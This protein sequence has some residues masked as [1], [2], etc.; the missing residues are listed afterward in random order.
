MSLAAGALVV[1]VALA[2]TRTE[3]IGGLGVGL[4]EPITRSFTM[5]DCGRLSWVSFLGQGAHCW[6]LLYPLK[7]AFV[8][9]FLLVVTLPF[10][11]R[12]FDAI[13]A[14]RTERTD[15]LW[16]ATLLPLLAGAIFTTSFYFTE[17][18]QLM[19][20]DNIRYLTPAMVPF[21]WLVLPQ[22]RFEGDL[23]DVGSPRI[24]RRHHLW[25][26]LAVGSYFVLELLHPIAGHATLGR[27]LLFFVL[28]LVPL[29]LGLVAYGTRYAIKERQVQGGVERRFV[30]AQAR[31]PEA[32]VVLGAV[33]V[34]LLAAWYFSAW[35]VTVGIGLVVALTAVSGKARALAMALVLLGSSAAGVQ[36]GLPL[37]ESAD[38]LARLPPG[39]H[40]GITEQIVYPAAVTPGH[41]VIRLIDPLEPIPPEMDALLIQHTFA[42]PG[43]TYEGFT[44]VREWQYDFQISPTLQ[45]PL[46]I[47]QN[48]LGQVVAFE[49][50]P[51]QT[52]YVRNGT[53][54]VELYR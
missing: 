54:L 49:D 52:L 23:A 32:R 4:I 53:G 40:V 21:L 45:A 14:G 10:S 36:S 5:A 20:F 51:G 33:A 2:L 35:Y 37:D 22:W 31:R 16:L 25:F 44:R 1:L 12:L 39:T 47:E 8:G 29:A 3:R 24:A 19:D 6:F 26:G 27:L 15:A 48:L 18:R 7:V 13:R 28:A 11:L 34:L 9:A 38:A 41:V 50:A 46:W 43:I 17:G 42:D 30:P